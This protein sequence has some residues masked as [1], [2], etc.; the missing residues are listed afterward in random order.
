MNTKTVSVSRTVLI[1]G[2]LIAVIAVALCTWSITK[3]DSNG[4]QSPLTLYDANGVFL[5]NLI[6]FDNDVPV[7]TY[8][9]FLPGYGIL[10]I[11]LDVS[12]PRIMANETT[13][14]LFYTTPDCTG[15]MYEDNT[16][17]YF[18]DPNI[19]IQVH[20]ADTYKAA[21]SVDENVNANIQ[22]SEFG[23]VC[24]QVSG[25]VYAQYKELV[26][27]QLP[28]TLSVVAGYGLLGPFTIVSN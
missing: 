5:G 15:T 27:I 28:F 13:F 2:A 10:H 20:N 22:S 14:T 19:I 3:A 26:H 11:S 6:S 18:T 12:G 17:Q 1:V 24:T 4:S 16:S 9:T 23:G 8:T 7:D 21:T 25:D